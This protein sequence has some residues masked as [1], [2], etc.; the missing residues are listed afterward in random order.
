MS[1][2]YAGGG[3]AA[4]ILRAPHTSDAQRTRRRNSAVTSCTTRN[5]VSTPYIQRG[6]SSNKTT[7]WDVLYK[8]LRAEL[9]HRPQHIRCTR[10]DA[11]PSGC[12]IREVVAGAHDV[13]WCCVHQLTPLCRPSRVV[14]GTVLPVGAHWCCRRGIAGA[15][16]L[17]HIAKVGARDS[18]PERPL[19][20]QRGRTYCT[21]TAARLTYGN[22]KL[23]HMCVTF[24]NPCKTSAAVQVWD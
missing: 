23:S 7:H 8:L 9:I 24:A 11:R 22:S 5:A 14:C 10:P 6:P 18:E 16:K 17:H 2:R 20:C 3:R 13:T 12:K 4:S 21:A 15:Y 1:L 19:T